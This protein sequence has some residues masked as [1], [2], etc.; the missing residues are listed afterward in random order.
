MALENSGA[1]NYI[2]NESNCQDNVDSPITTNIFYRVYDYSENIYKYYCSFENS[3][4][5]TITKFEN[6]IVS[7]T[8]SCTAI[9]RDDANDFIEITQGRFDINRATISGTEFP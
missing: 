5:I 3:G 7:G 9:N 4:L 8:F 2:V 1:G 6:G